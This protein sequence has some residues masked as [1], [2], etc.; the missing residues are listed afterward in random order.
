V[1]TA[2]REEGSSTVLV[3]GFVT[4]LLLLG[5]LVASL[6]ALTVTRH[7]AE[8]AADLAALAAAGKA[9]E[10]ETAACAAAR[11]VA[12][13]QHGRVLSC[14]LEGLDARV[15]VGVRAPGRL[16]ELGLVRGRAKAGRRRAGT[17]DMAFA[18]YPEKAGRVAR[19]A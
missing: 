11:R 16:G 15:E 14:R 9:F 17:R 2:R 5:G 6:A 13:A 18:S 7:Q 3:L 10:G 1:T 8:A 4:V 12:A 19:S